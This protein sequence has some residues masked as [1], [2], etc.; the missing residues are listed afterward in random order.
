MPATDSPLDIQVAWRL[1]KSWH[2]ASLLRRVA[3]HVAS[4]EGFRTGQLSVAVVGG[5]A[6]TTLHQR[7][8][9][10]AEP[11]DVL[12]FDLGTD[13]GR[14]RLDGEIVLCADVARRRCRSRLSRRVPA[15]A[16][17]ELALYL[18]HGILHLAG[19]DDHSPAAFRRMH[20]RED[21]L[22]CELG[23]GPVFHGKGS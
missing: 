10:V 22:L 20:T 18:T 9:G 7:Y 12:A 17:A 5:R 13:R 8:L 19:Y 15:A 6:M 14:A 4:A 11:T 16:R 3:A 21:H 2:A 23:L 1:R